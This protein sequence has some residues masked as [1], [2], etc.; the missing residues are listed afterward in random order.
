M[1]AFSYIAEMH[2]LLQ[3]VLLFCLAGTTAFAQIRVD[4]IASSCDAITLQFT[5]TEDITS[6]FSQGVATEVAVLDTLP[7]ISVRVYISL[8]PNQLVGEGV[9]RLMTL[10][11][12]T[13][14]VHIQQLDARLLPPPAI[15]PDNEQLCEGERTQLQVTGNFSSY[16]W[17]N[18]ATS[19]SISVGG[20]S[21]TVRVRTLDGC[22]ASTSISIS[23][24]PAPAVPF[25]QNLSG[26]TVLCEGET[27]ELSTFSSSYQRIVWST[28]ETTASILVSSS[29]SYTVTGFNALGCHATSET[30]RINVL[31]APLAIV[32]ASSGVYA[33]QGGHATQPVQGTFEIVNTSSEVV[34]LQLHD[35]QFAANAEFS[36]PPAQF[37]VQISPYDSLVLE[38]IFWPN[39]FDE[40]SDV[41]TIKNGCRDILYTF[42]GFPERNV[43]RG[44]GRC[45]VPLVGDV[46][47]RRINIS[48]LYPSVANSVVHMQSSSSTQPVE[49]PF[50][51][52]NLSSGKVVDS[53]RLHIARGEN[54][55]AVDISKLPSGVYAMTLQGD[56]FVQQSFIKY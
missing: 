53:G 49:I 30:M 14:F 35:I 26:R 5:S 37:P 52:V 41:L 7:N 43:L 6:V 31:P 2:T 9:V 50:F 28:G 3:Y 51:I 38:Y 39:G 4:T 56:L 17:S 16:E 11:S 12:P 34:E 18:G 27:T 25:V 19:A 10:A 48:H 33:I 47:D 46:K 54:V 1:T 36:V 29:G 22:V 20:G 44:A 8:V 42:A 15:V 55:H 24:L 32:P 45:T 13:E 40:T 21:Y 23:E